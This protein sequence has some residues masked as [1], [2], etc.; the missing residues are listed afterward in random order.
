[1]RDE[2]FTNRSEGGEKWIM[3]KEWEEWV[4]EAPVQAGNAF[5][6]RAVIAN[7]ISRDSPAIRRHAR[8]AGGRWRGGNQ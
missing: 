7:R 5:V 8:T 3:N 1:M 6:M 2:F 4:A